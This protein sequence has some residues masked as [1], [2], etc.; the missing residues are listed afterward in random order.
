MSK[1]L[2][3]QDLVSRLTFDWRIIRTMSSAQYVFTAHRTAQHAAAGTSPIGDERD[4][5]YA[6][7]YRLQFNIPTLIG[8]GQ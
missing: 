5:R 7:H 8:P 3:P 4:A 6:M 2:S 1:S